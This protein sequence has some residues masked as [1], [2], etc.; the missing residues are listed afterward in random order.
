MKLEKEKAALQ[1]GAA[2]CIIKRLDFLE[3]K[4]LFTQ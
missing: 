1:N 2:F 3:K 4:G